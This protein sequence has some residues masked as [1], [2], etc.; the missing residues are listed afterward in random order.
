MVR[1]VH[2]GAGYLSSSSKRVHFGLGDASIVSEVRIRW[3][4]GTE[5]VLTDVRGDRLVTIREDGE[6][7]VTVMLPEGI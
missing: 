4:S 7:A 5:T 2:S 3:L 6:A 1:A